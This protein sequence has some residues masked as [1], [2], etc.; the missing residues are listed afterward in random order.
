MANRS[1]STPTTQ[2]ADTIPHNS[3]HLPEDSDC[4]APSAIGEP[5]TAPNLSAEGGTREREGAKLKRQKKKFFC[6]C[7]E[8]DVESARSLPTSVAW[9][10]MSAIANGQYTRG[11]SEAAQAAL[12][13]ACYQAPLSRGHSL[14]EN[15]CKSLLVL[16]PTIQVGDVGRHRIDDLPTKL[17]ELRAVFELTSKGMG[18][19][20]D[21]L[22]VNLR[23]EHG[24]QHAPVRV[25]GIVKVLV[26]P[27]DNRSGPYKFVGAVAD[28]P[29]FIRLRDSIDS[30]LAQF[31]LPLSRIYVPDMSLAS[32]ISG[33]R[34]IL[35]ARLE[36]AVHEGSVLRQ[37]LHY[38][39]TQHKDFVRQVFI[40]IPIPLLSRSHLLLTQAD[41]EKKEA[42]VLHKR[43]VDGLTKRMAEIQVSADTAYQRGQQGILKCQEDLS[44]A[45][46]K[47][48]SSLEAME[49]LRQQLSEVIFLF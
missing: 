7:C 11:L 4:R 36:R 19:V 32:A 37:Q 30:R 47:E 12:C 46:R 39:D 48:A 3:T 38:I 29:G 34:H 31:E 16:A 18:H 40:Q 25:D 9:R 35:E 41:I 10:L 6:F 49:V 24:W 15:T 28:K 14:L 1:T 43:I 17:R 8:K 27:G 45:S 2:P 20:F 22:L 26:F 13:D 5:G 44:M 23:S 33:E 42:A 21:M